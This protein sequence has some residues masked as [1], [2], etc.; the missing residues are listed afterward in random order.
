M[1]RPRSARFAGS[2]KNPRIGACSNAPGQTPALPPGGP[3]DRPGCGVTSDIRSG[4]R[5]GHGSRIRGPDRVSSCRAPEAVDLLSYTPTQK[6]L[7]PERFPAMQGNGS[8]PCARP[9]STAHT[10]PKATAPPLP[11]LSPPPTNAQ[12]RATASGAADRERD[13]GTSTAS[14]RLPA[15]PRPVSHGRTGRFHLRRKVFESG[16]IF[17]KGDLPG[18][19]ASP[20]V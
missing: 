11:N 20:G 2:D 7:F 16:A 12:S 1:I 10:S 9:I 15:R 17:E 6:A 8:T 5:M 14:I 3:M 4:V 19:F 18:L 13:A